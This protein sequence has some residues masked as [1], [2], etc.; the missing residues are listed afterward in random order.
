[1]SIS[2]FENNISPWEKK[3]PK[4]S[5]QMEEKNAKVMSAYF[6]NI[7]EQLNSSISSLPKSIF[8]DMDEI[9]PIEFE[10]EFSMSVD[11]T[12]GEDIFNITDEEFA[13][14]SSNKSR[15]DQKNKD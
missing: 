12:L 7:S 11:E 10:E 13:Q 15:K 9:E 3:V 6:R 14:K 2:F 8:G 1:M 5:K 4:I